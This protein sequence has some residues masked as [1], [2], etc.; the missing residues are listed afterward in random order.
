MLSGALYMKLIKREKYL[1][2]LIGFK[3]T[4]DIKIITGIRRSG[5]SQLLKLYID[6]LK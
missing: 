5:K 3:G 2:R 4:F 6:Y 1:D